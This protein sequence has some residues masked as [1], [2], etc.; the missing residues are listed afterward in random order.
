MTT[1]A[2]RELIQIAGIEVEVFQMPNGEYVMSQT[3]VAEAVDTARISIVRFWE[4]SGSKPLPGNDSELYRLAVEGS[5]KPIN[6][7]PAD[8]VTDY[9][10]EQ[11]FKGNIKAKALVKACAHEALQRRCDNVFGVA[12]TE[13]QYEQQA[14]TH[15]ERWEARRK[16]LREQHTNFEYACKTYGFSCASTHNKLTM[17]AVQK[18]AKELKELEVIQGSKDVGLNHIEDSDELLLVA[19]VKRHFSRYRTGGVDDR[20]RRALK[21]AHKEK[22]TLCSSIGG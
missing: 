4:V 13:Y 2:K 17:A 19:K 5:N 9:W 20:I 6:I 10:F 16:Y 1:K 12:K 22:N 7:I 3:Q 15:R 18:T 11:A 14:T 21:E 8:I